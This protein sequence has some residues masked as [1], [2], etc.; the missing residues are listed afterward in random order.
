MCEIL[1]LQQSPRHAGR[2]MAICAEHEHE[3]EHEHGGSLIA[4][5]RLLGRFL[6]GALPQSAAEVPVWALA[7]PH[8][9]WNEVCRYDGATFGDRYGGGLGRAARPLYLAFLVLWPF[10]AVWRALRRG[11][12]AGRYL[13]HALA[14]PDLAMLNPWAD[15]TES[16]V[17]WGRPDQALGMLY[18]VEFSRARSEFLWLDDKRRFLEAAAREG[19]PLPRGFTPAEAAARGGAFIVKDPE[20]DLGYGVRA[21][22]AEEIRALG[23]GAEGLIIQERLKNHAALLAA[24]PDDAPLCSFR[25]ITTL[26]PETR[27]PRVSRCAIR[28][29]RAGV[30]VDNTQQGGIWSRLDPDTGAICDGVTKKTFGLRRK[31]AP[32]R[33]TVHPDTGRSFV[34]LRIPWWDEGRRLAL[35][36]HR[37]LSP[38]ALSMGWDL[39]LAEGAPCFLE[40]NVWTAS[41]DYDPPDDAFTP[42][43][44]LILRRLGELF[45]A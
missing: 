26:D 30:P 40:V 11:R 32:V 7:V 28:M 24:L 36:A 33:E 3:H 5:W 2:G 17:R 22:D 18:A 43:C 35:E 34:G 29:G 39:A 19:F 21:M 45:T 13:R 42:A 8:R 4:Y 23:A 27:E 1:Q 20:D 44:A 37:K 15:F 12:E 14:R 9:M 31:G 10:I 6:G 38:Q 41:Y 16:E 25:V